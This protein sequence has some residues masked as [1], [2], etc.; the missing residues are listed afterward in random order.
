[1][2]FRSRTWIYRPVHYRDEEQW[3]DVGGGRYGPREPGAQRL[4]APCRLLADGK[5]K[6]VNLD[7]ICPWDTTAPSVSERR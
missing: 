1:M 5:N 4:G 6:K 7:W 3:A 2:E